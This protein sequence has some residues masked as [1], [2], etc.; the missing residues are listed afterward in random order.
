MA[1][2]AS[3]FHPGRAAARTSSTP[4]LLRR[5][6]K[7]YA[8]VEPDADRLAGTRFLS[9][10]GPS[11]TPSMPAGTGELCFLLICKENFSPIGDGT[12]SS[13]SRVGTVVSTRRFAEM[14]SMLAIHRSS[15]DFSQQRLGQQRLGQQ[16]FGRDFSQQ[17]SVSR[18]QSAEP[19]SAELSQHTRHPHLFL[20]TTQWY[21][22]PARLPHTHTLPKAGTCVCE[23]EIARASFPSLSLLL[24]PCGVRAQG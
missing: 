5:S 8:S 17:S 2:L 23:G 9:K 10:K 12:S 16:T 21:A 3:T 22:P 4:Q 6:C 24:R 13:V 11:S 15:S 1:A 7:N 20:H 18:A 14:L 19:Q